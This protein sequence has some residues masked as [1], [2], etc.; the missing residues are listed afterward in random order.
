MTRA[1]LTAIF[2]TLLSQT[3]WGDGFSGV[4]K[5]SS[6]QAQVSDSAI[7]TTYKDLLIKSGNF[8]ALS[9]LN[10]YVN[11]GVIIFSGSVNSRKDWA[12][13][14][15]I[16]ESL[17]GV[18]GF[19]NDLSYNSSLAPIT[20]SKPVKPSTGT[21]NPGVSDVTNQPSANKRV[22]SPAAPNRRETKITDASASSQACVNLQK[23]INKHI[24]NS[25]YERAQQAMKLMKSMNCGNSGNSVSEQKSKQRYTSVD[26]ACSVGPLW[27]P[28][29]GRKTGYFSASAFDDNPRSSCQVAAS[30]CDAYAQAAASGAQAPPEFKQPDSYRA[31]CYSY[32]RSTD[33]TINPNVGGG[34]FVGG[35]AEG[36]SKGLR[37]LMAKKQALMA[38]FRTCMAN[39]GYSLA[40][41]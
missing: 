23:K 41:R 17:N 40:E 31:D 9:R 29:F 3:A 24:S 11:R 34:G 28:N 27:K 15:Q 7:L 32:G 4:Q 2:L 14:K 16:G 19:K 33:C 35:F 20:L 26:L 5:V 18:T 13:L 10:I 8:R 36:L 12:A 38:T 21:S 39:E 30:K 6:S 37:G 22:I 1:L 25:E